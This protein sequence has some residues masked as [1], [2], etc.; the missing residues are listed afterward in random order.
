MLWLIVSIV[1]PQC[2]VCFFS[3]RSF[4]CLFFLS[5]VVLPVKCYKIDLYKH[6]FFIKH[7]FFKQCLQG[8]TYIT[9]SVFKVTENGIKDPPA[10]LSCKRC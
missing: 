8:R 7:M 6:T 10:I 5:C 4:V 3:P 9:A 2:F 1:L